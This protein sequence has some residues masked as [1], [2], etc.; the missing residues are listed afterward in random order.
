MIG[1][2]VSNKLLILKTIYIK[3]IAILA[4]NKVEESELKS[5][6]ETMEKESFTVDIIST[7]SDEI[8]DWAAGN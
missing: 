1:N 6:K 5:P 7:K 4:I 3:T 2:L 8:K